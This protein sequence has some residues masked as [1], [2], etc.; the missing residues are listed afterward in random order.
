M[1]LYGLCCEIKSV[2]SVIL[3]I[4]SDVGAELQKLQSS[5]LSWFQTYTSDKFFVLNKQIAGLKEN[6]KCLTTI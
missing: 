3:Y 2:C 6:F 1:K 4:C 5:V